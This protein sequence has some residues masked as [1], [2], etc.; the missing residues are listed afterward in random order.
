[1]RSKLSFAPIGI[2]GGDARD[3]RQHSTSQ[4]LYGGP[5]VLVGV[6]GFGSLVE[7]VCFAFFMCFDL[8]FGLFD[9]FSHC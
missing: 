8:L 2:R 6:G 1:M 9:L 5:A 7:S 3:R 4:Y